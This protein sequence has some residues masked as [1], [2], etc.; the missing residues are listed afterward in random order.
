MITFYLK[1]LNKRKVNLSF[2]DEQG[3]REALHRAALYILEMPK[4]ELLDLVEYYG[5][6]ETP[7][8]DRIIP[9]FI[10]SL[11]PSSIKEWMALLRILPSLFDEEIYPLDGSTSAKRALELALEKDVH[12]ELMMWD[13]PKA[14]EA[15]EPLKKE[16]DDPYADWDAEQWKQAYLALSDYAE[17]A[18][19][20]Y[21]AQN[22]GIETKSW[23]IAEELRERYRAYRKRGIMTWEGVALRRE[24]QSLGIATDNWVEE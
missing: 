11:T 14:Q 7:L 21:N 6:E 15:H 5:D 17:R 1:L 13:H 2:K 19:V 9:V 10:E 23:P 12:S 20:R 16:V 8:L 4:S 24:A 22:H 18:K 3:Y